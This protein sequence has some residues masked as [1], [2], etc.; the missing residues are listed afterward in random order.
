MKRKVNTPPPPSTRLSLPP[1]PLSLSNSLS[2]Y[3]LGLQ[4]SCALC[5][6]CHPKSESPQRPL[7]S[8]GSSLT[9]IP[10]PF[11]VQLLLWFCKRLGYL[12]VPWGRDLMK[13]KVL[14]YWKVGLI[15][16]NTCSFSY[17]LI[18]ASPLENRTSISAALTGACTYGMSAGWAHIAVCVVG[19]VSLRD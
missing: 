3:L 9:Y 11:H 13:V 14:E 18:R 10:L 1:P 5:P 8:L 6:Q 17:F 4:S 2:L 19:R 12:H 7:F 16:F 15:I